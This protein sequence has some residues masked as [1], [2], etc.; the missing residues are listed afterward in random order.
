[1]EQLLTKSI[2]ILTPV[3]LALLSLGVAY[4]IMY[5]NKAKAKV[6]VETQKIENEQQRQ[7][8]NSAV[9]DLDKLLHQNILFAE[10]TL[11]K[12]IKQATSDN[13]LSMEEGEEVANAVVNNVLSQL[14][15]DNKQL[16]ANQ[17]N[18][19]EKYIRAEVETILKQIKDKTISVK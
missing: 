15:E 7:L 9:E 1:M 19:L 6:L 18:S 2:E 8:V 14:T 3:V 12:E 11:V 5:L 4:V 13:K 17:S 16:L 10:G